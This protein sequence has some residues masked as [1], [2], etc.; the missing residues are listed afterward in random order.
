ML[1]VPSLAGNCGMGNQG[2]EAIQG[3][4]KDHSRNTLCIALGLTDLK[5]TD[6][7]E[8]LEEK[9][10]EEE[11]E[12]DGNEE[13]EDEE[14]VEPQPVGGVSR[15][16]K[17]KDK[18]AAPQTHGKRTV[19]SSRKRKSRPVETTVEYKTRPVP[20]PPIVRHRQRFM[21]CQAYDTAQSQE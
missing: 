2:R 19:P 17:S 5:R 15:Q 9:E 16:Q 10:E 14:D 3:F 11:E 4:R 20:L 13:E 6:S 1:I 21:T 8:V 7:H 12:E 18:H